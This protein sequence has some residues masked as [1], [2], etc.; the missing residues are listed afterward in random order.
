MFIN[1]G[2]SKGKHTIL[3]IHWRD[4]AL[5]SGLMNYVT[6]SVRSLYKKCTRPLEV[7]MQNK[8]KTEF[9]ISSL[10]RSILTAAVC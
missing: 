7:D 1:R 10:I 2:V 6:K 8:P 4:T 9:S 3:Q 5:Y